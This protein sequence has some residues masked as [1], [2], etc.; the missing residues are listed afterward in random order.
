MT[1]PPDEMRLLTLTQ[2]WASLI[3]PESDAKHIE[4]RS[5]STSYRGWIAIH[6]GKGLGPVGGLY[7]LQQFVLTSAFRQ[8]PIARNWD[9]HAFSHPQLYLPFGKIVAVARIADCAKTDDVI[10]TPTERAFGDYTPGR[11]A[12]LLHDIRRLRR[13]V[14]YRGAQGLQRLSAET[15]SAVWKEVV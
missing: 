7:G 3:G 6:A 1:T 8:S 12:W 14:A 11:W 4:T 13:P 10:V 2:P 5:R 9:G 15:I